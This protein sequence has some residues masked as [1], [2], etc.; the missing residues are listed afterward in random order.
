MASKKK[1]SNKE[2]K[3]KLD[4]SKKDF[5]AEIEQMLVERKKDSKY[6]FFGSQIKGS[7][8]GSFGLYK[9]LPF[10]TSVELIHNE[11]DKPVYEAYFLFPG[12]REASAT[13]NKSGQEALDK[14]EIKVRKGFKPL[15]DMLGV[16]LDQKE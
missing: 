2:G 16:S 1:K 14:L 4:T 6:F 9:S 13:S 15:L 10:D 5:L 12:Y 7:T 11:K 3:I 8:L